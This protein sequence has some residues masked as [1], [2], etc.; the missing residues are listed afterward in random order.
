MDDAIMMTG[1][2]GSSSTI[3]Y[4][5]GG[6]PLTCGHCNCAPCQCHLRFDYSPTFTYTVEKPTRVKLTPA[7]LDA[8]RKAADESEDL[9]AVLRKLAPCIEVEVAFP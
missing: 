1:I 2:G 7:E 8:L 4:P 9:K 5:W 3:D 6:Y